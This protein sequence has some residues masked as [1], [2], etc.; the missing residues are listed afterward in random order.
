MRPA[1][2]EFPF[3]KLP[4]DFEAARMAAK[5]VEGTQQWQSFSAKS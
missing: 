5:I 3:G 1:P 4:G 2:W